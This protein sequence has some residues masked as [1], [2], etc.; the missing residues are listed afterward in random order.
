[1]KSNPLFRVT[2][3]AL[4]TAVMACSGGDDSSNLDAGD[5]SNDVSTMDQTAPDAAKPDATP[6]ATLPDAGVDADVDAGDDAN[7]GAPD[8]D[9]GNDASTLPPE[10]SPC[11]NPAEVQTE[12]CGFCGTHDRACLSDGKGGHVWAPWGYCQGQ[13]NNACD[14]DST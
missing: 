2:L 13:P 5:A 4:S 12:P 11:T 9:A 10:G 6:D 8:L 7:D 14:P 1:M 3:V